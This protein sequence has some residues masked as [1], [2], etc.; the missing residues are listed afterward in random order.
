[1]A[2]FLFGLR[3]TEVGHE[4]CPGTIESLHDAGEEAEGCDYPARIEGRVIGH[5]VEN[6]SENHI[7]CELIQRWCGVDEANMGYIIP[8][9]ANMECSNFTHDVARDKYR[10]GKRKKQGCFPGGKVAV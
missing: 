8:E 7:V 6:S 4:R 9:F 3:E 2:Y 1:M 10:G 5:V